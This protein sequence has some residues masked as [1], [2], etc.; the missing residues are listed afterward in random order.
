MTLQRGQA[1]S[2]ESPFR[3]AE[4]AAVD[5]RA[6]TATPKITKAS[7]AMDAVKVRR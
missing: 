6:A 4:L 1:F 2:M 3:N 5:D 7:D